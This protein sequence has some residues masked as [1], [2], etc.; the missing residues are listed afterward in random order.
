MGKGEKML[1]PNCSE[2][3]LRVDMTVFD[4]INDCDGFELFLKTI[5]NL[6]E[7]GISGNRIFINPEDGGHL[8]LFKE[9]INEPEENYKEYEKP[10]KYY[11]KFID[12]R[13]WYELQ[14]EY[15][16]NKVGEKNV[17]SKLQ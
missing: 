2:I 5:D 12:E 16:K 3:I 13:E 17:N 8:D 11:E 4:S 7:I 14:K 1:N 15:E 10:K 6:L 9:W